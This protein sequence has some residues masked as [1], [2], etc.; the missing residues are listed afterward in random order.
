[1]FKSGAVTEPANYR[2]IMVVGALPR[3]Q[4]TV[5][6]RR[7]LDFAAG[8]GL[9]HLSQAGFLQNRSCAEQLLLADLI[10]SHCKTHSNKHLTCFLDLSRAYGNT[11]H[12]LLLNQLHKVGVTGRMWLYFS[13]FLREQRAFVQVGDQRSTEFQLQRG[14]Y[15]GAIWSP[16][17]FILFL[18][19]PT[20][21]LTGCR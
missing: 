1:M 4:Q 17:L 14:L 15:E 18:D 21:R 11:N 7:L 9:L 3:I 20:T 16:L 2:S 10:S 12:T 5:L 13:R 6:Y 8:K 19:P